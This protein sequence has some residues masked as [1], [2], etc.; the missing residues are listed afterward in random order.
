MAKAYVLYNPLAGNGSAYDTVITLKDVLDDDIEFFD[1]RDGALCR[2]MLSS[3]DKNDYIVICGG[4]GTLNHFINDMQ[5]VR[6]END[7]LYYPV[8]SGNDFARELGKSKGD[9]PFSV[10][11]YLE[12][13]PCVTVFGKKYRFI[14]GIGFGL[15]GYCCEEGDRLRAASKKIDY[16][17]IAIKG[18]LFHYKPTKARV[19]VDGK[20]YNYK[21]VWIAPTMFG[22]HYG[23]GMIPT[24][25]QSRTKTPNNVS[26]LI[27]HNACSLKVLMIFPSIFKGEHISYK[28]N[29]SIISG[30]SITVEFDRPAP[31]QIDGETIVNV[32]SYTVNAYEDE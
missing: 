5:D 3:L 23:G 29:V 16:T 13:L 30:K 10:K 17:A 4:D 21:R 25:S 7:V 9:K 12:R 28:K 18:L 14:N 26:T 24:P 2:D 31:L 15:D 8:G 19:I 22:K 1:I 11:K 32:T 27:L 20:E 6:L